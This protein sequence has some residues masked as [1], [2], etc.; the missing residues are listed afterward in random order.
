MDMVSR[1]EL[2]QNYIVHHMSFLWHIH[3]LYEINDCSEVD[4]IYI[5]RE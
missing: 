5:Q 2:Q 3:N 4:N 1:N